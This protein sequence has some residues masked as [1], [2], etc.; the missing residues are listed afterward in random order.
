MALAGSLGKQVAEVTLERSSNRDFHH[1]GKKK[2]E[3]LMQ[4]SEWSQISSPGPQIIYWLFG[5]KTSYTKNVD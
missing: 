3:L 5:K 1:T 4:A 2:S